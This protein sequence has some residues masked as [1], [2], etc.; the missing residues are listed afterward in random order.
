MKK[1]KLPIIDKKNFP[2]TLVMVYWED[3][4]GDASW[5]DITDIKKSKTAVC[6]SFGWLVTHNSKTTVVMADFIFEDSS[7]IKQGGGYTTIPTKNVL[8]IKKIKL[9]ERP[10]ARKKKTRTV[11]DVIEDIRELHEKEEDLLMELEDL[12]EES[13]IDEGEE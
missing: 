11:S 9:Q 5:A 10:M 3:I 7:K 4:V 12:T 13:D 8:S 2:Y 6:C 1:N